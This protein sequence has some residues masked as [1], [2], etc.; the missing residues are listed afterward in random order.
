MLESQFR[1]VASAYASAQATIRFADEK[2][3]TLFIICGILMAFLSLRVDE[4]LWVL[5][6]PAGFPLLP[7]VTFLLFCVFVCLM[8]WALGL[9][10]ATVRPR[11]AP[12]G[13]AGAA[14]RRRLH[15]YHDVLD[16]DRERYLAAVRALSDDDVLA[17]MAHELYDAQG[18]ERKKFTRI[19]RAIR[20]TGWSLIVWNVT[21]ILSCFL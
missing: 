1:F 20:V 13:A 19:N 21:F 7:V 6:R 17:E 11:F 10:V 12:R 8:F 9:A 3:E 15:W 14:G 18:I 16:R 2:A 4:A 5:R